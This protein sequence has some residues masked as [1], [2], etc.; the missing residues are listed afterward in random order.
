MTQKFTYIKD[1]VSGDKIQDFFILAEAQMRESRNGPFWNLTL[2]DCSGRI[3]AKVW[4][5]LSQNIPQLSSGMFIRAGGSIGT[6]R[7]KLQFTVEAL[8]VVDERQLGLELSDYLPCSKVDPETMLQEID[9]LIAEYMTYKP[10]KKFC[11]NVLKSSSIR[12]R[13][14]MATGAKSV[15]HAYIG[16]LLEHTLSVCK[17]C[18]SISSNYP[19]I[20][21]QAVLAAAIFHDLGKAWELS[22]G[23]V[24]DY[25]DEGRLLGHIYIGLEKLEPFLAREKSLPDELKLH[26]KHLI[27]SHHG[28]YEYGSPKRPKTPEAFVLHYADNIDAKMNTVFAELEK[29]EGTEKQWTPFQ[30]YLD[31]YLYRAEVTPVAKDKKLEE[32]K[33]GNQCLL[34]LKE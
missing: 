29:L 13:L 16:G 9:Y 28:E 5:P 26:L 8:D 18:M 4:S 6:F 19:G 27:L 23:L 32:V 10:W 21:R 1:F 25:T 7:D 3:E 14:L 2:Q 17:L 15:H 30:R 34:P 33:D 22:G 12:E 24:N 20:D 31:R 11:R